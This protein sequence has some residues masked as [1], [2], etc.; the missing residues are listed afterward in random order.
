MLLKGYEYI[1][2]DSYTVNIV[3]QNN[4]FLTVIR[5]IQSE[6]EWKSEYVVLLGPLKDPY[7]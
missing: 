7:C 4:L 2:T 6:L 1:T 5:I 3:T